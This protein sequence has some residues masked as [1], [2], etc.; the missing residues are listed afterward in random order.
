MFYR[1]L[2]P[3]LAPVPAPPRSAK[4]MTSLMPAA[5]CSSSK[6]VIHS[7]ESHHF[8]S[9]SSKALDLISLIVS[10]SGLMPLKRRL[11]IRISCHSAVVR[12]KK[13]RLD[14]K[15]YTDEMSVINIGRRIKSMK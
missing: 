11:S 1:L 10:D 4:E 14:S 5:S 6:A 15:G 3:A 2:A 7:L 12:W 8:S 13:S 9:L